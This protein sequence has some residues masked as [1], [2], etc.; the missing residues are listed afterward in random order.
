MTEIVHFRA[1]RPARLAERVP[2]DDLTA[3]VRD[4][5]AVLRSA[6]VEPLPG[7]VRLVLALDPHAI[8]RLADVVR[9]GADALPFWTFRLLAD[10]PACWLE[11][12]GAGRA[13]VLARAVFEE[14]A[15]A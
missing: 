12:S 3:H 7:G 15:S 6:R 4:F 13:G 14:L 9:G 11:V 10:P 1:I 2:L 5:H 8:A